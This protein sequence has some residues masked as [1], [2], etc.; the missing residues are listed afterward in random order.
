MTPTQIHALE[1][2]PSLDF[3]QNGTEGFGM[4][5]ALRLARGVREPF[6]PVV[7]YGVD[8]LDEDAPEWYAAIFSRAMLPRQATDTADRQLRPGIQ[9][10][11]VA[12]FMTTLTWLHRGACEN[13]M[14]GGEY[15]V[16]PFDRVP[17]A[18]RRQLAKWG[19][20]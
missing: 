14:Y 11:A 20:A 13:G 15:T 1:R 12:P 10:L 3:D 9:V 18:V 7:E 19:A 5:W 6:G 2:S 16:I 4:L 8:E 17:R